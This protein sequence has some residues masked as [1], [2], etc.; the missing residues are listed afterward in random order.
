MLVAFQVYA[1]VN[2]VTQSPKT[3]PPPNNPKV[4]HT[5]ALSK[6]DRIKPVKLNQ[7]IH[8][9][10]Q[11]NLFNVRVD[12]QPGRAFEPEDLNLEKTSLKLTLWGTVTGKNKEDGWAVIKDQKAKRQELYRVNDKIQG[13]TIKAILRNKII[14]TVNGKDQM[15]EVDENSLSSQNRKRQIPDTMP[16]A[17]IP[18]RTLPNPGMPDSASQSNQ[19][20][21]TRP[22]FR[23]GQASGVMVYSIKRGSVAQLLG[24]RNG[25][26]IQAVDD[27]E[28]QDVQDLENF[29]ENIDE[30]SD[31]TISIIR[32][33]KVKELVFSAE[34]NTHNLNDV[35]Q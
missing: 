35:E 28:I 7:I 26:I 18:P 17:S 19:L 20:F 25:D 23:D 13:A 12:G 14:L 3:Q 31:L 22:Y 32:R 8:R 9:V 4:D 34:D 2:P 10:T 6:L 11:R 30:Q 33:G 1:L 27:V 15:L 16:T 5:Q 21:K 24:L 29:D